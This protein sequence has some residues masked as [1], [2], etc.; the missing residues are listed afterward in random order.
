M[1]IIKE[2]VFSKTV[3]EFTAVAKEYCAFIEN[4]TDFK[5]K[6]FIQVA[7]SL[8][9]LLYYKAS[10]LP[11]T[12]PMYEQVNQK[13]VTEEHYMALHERTKHF[14]G[15]Y[16]AFPEV[17]DKRTAETDDQFAASLSEYLCD[18]YQDLKDFTMIYQNGQAEEINDALWECKLNFG[19]F[20]G[21]RLANSIRAIHQ[22][23]YSDLELVTE[24]PKGSE[25]NDNIDTSDWFITRRQNEMDNK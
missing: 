14:L 24:S 22:L 25:Q 11:S 8:L 23:A 17:F 1:T 15:Q 19:D 21:I 16:D 13:H 6:Q 10:L 2:L 3:V 9:P 20:W 18:I 7:N 5:L 4:S 12:S